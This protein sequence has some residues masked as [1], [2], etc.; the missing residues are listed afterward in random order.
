M[1]IG[2]SSPQ[3]TFVVSN[4]GAQGLEIGWDDGTSQFLQAYN[5]SGAAWIPIRIQGSDIRFNISGSTNEAARID[6]SKRLLVGTASTSRTTRISVTGNSAGNSNEHGIAD[7]QFSGTAPGNGWA[8]GYLNF[9]DTSTG[10]AARI[11]AERDGGT[12]TSGSSMPGRLVFFTT[13]DGAS[14]PTERMRL[15][16]NGTATFFN[17]VNS[18]EET[19]TAEAFDLAA[20]NFWTCDAIVIPNPTN[21]VAGMSGL[22][23]LT[24]APIGWGNNFSTAPAPTVFPSI[25]P[26]YVESSTSIR[27][28]QAVGVV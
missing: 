22:I 6:S 16:Q 8:L 5:R 10:N 23:R 26:F 18:P 21:A 12:W 15:S 25:V 27:L 11:G 14:S 2:T 9:A 1:G 20:G 17:S 19:I 7:F 3:T 24:A 13:A 28:G 4:G